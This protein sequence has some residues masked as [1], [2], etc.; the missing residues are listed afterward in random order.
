MATRLV[1]GAFREVWREIVPLDGGASQLVTTNIACDTSGLPKIDAR[2]VLDSVNGGPQLTATLG[3]ANKRLTI[4]IANTAPAGNLATWTLDVTLNH[5]A[6]Q[7]RGLGAAPTPAPV[8]VI[9]GGNAVTGTPLRAEVAQVA[10]S[11]AQYTSIAA[12]LA[13]VTP[14]ATALTPWVVQVAAGTYFEPPMTVPPYVTVE[15][16]GFVV[17]VPTSNGADLFTG[18]GSSFVNYLTILCP[19]GVGTAGFRVN[20]GGVGDALIANILFIG[21]GRYGLRVSAGGVQASNL[22]YGGGV[23]DK[24]VQVDGTGNCILTNTSYRTAVPA[25]TV[26]GFV[27]TGPAAVLRMSNC[28]FDAPGSIGTMVDDSGLLTLEG[29]QFIQGTIA[30]HVGNNGTPRMYARATSI[31]EDAT[32][33]FTTTIKVDTAAAVVHFQGSAPRN[34]FV[35]V[36]G[37]AL[38]ASFADVTPGDGGSTTIGDTYTARSANPNVAF[39]ESKYHLDTNWTGLRG[40]GDGGVTRA[41]GLKLDVAGDYGFINNNIDQFEIDWTT[42]QITLAPNTTEYVWIDQT[43]AIQH[44]P[45]QPNYANNIVL[46]QAVTD[47]ANVLLLTRD[48]IT[49]AHTLSRTQEFFEDVIGPI[50]LGGG[51]TTINGGDALKL[52]VDPGEF[53]VGLSERTIAGGAGVTFTYWY[54]T[55]GGWVGVPG[56]VHIDTTQYNDITSGLVAMTGTNW[57]KD[58]LYV[59]VNAGGTEYHVVYGQEQF[60][61]QVAAEQ[62]NYPAPPFI[63]SHYGMRSGGVVSQRN[64]VAITSTTDARPKIGG[65]ITTAG[66]SDH[67]ALTG[68][69]DDDHLQ[70]LTTGR[71]DTWHFSTPVAGE[72]HV[73][74]GNL[75]THSIAGDGGQV[76][77]TTLSNIGV[78]THVQID[79]H[80]ASTAN[81]HATTYTQVGAPPATR[82]LT[83]GAGLTGGGDLS[84]DRTFTVGANADG[85]I[86]VNA[87]DIQVGVLATDVQHG[88]R[89]GGA[90]HATVTADPGGVAGFMS[91]ADK[92]KLDGIPASA[93]PTTRTLTAGAGLTGGGDLSANR[94]FDVVANADGSIV[95]NADDIQV[96]VL[97]TDAQH[98]NRGGGGIHTLVVASGAAG[99]MSGADKTK[100]DGLPTSAVPTSRTINGFALTANIT[101]GA[102]DVSADVAGAAATVQGNLNTHAGL[103][104]TAHGGIVP[105][106]RTITAGNG[107]TGGGDLSANRALA[108][109]AANGSITVAA[110]GISVTFGTTATTACVGNDARLSDARL[111]LNYQQVN[112]PTRTTLTGAGSTSY[113]PAG[114]A[115]KLTMTTPA[116][117]AGTYKVSWSAVM[118][119]SSAARE[120][121]IRVQNTTDTVTLEE[122]L[123]RPTNAASP[124]VFTGYALVTFAGVAKTFAMQFHTANTGDTAGVQYAYLDIE[125]V[126]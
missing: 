46:A 74:N 123:F 107:L 41:G 126:L 95:V 10:K 83:A 68:L 57:K 103:T 59:I 102:A 72:A 39:P 26:H 96:G 61:T 58:L 70:Y 91:S 120:M 93:V 48:E 65:Y 87:N 113:P 20:G 108:V 97:A 14:L 73:K 52:D 43:G 89:G 9:L 28:L 51:A 25:S 122:V 11:G 60:A 4:T 64:A 71:A 69:G 42:T 105:S 45:A 31:Q 19:S 22:L 34:K 115:T 18:E 62:G 17:V 124:Q 29:V 49:I 75:H 6:Q 36:P 80:I 118:D 117:A 112:D 32:G 101:L 84:A 119:Y 66:V 121:S 63:L 109:L 40:D 3:I 27:C 24:Y 47:G 23:F 1:A 16:L 94:T 116:L 53:A 98:G 67:G 92:A 38:Q 77:H 90:L 44:G 13:V 88:N 111:P 125:R 76:D 21:S 54:E 7:N 99:F 106:A 35:L 56:Q 50:N 8:S 30:I 110:G 79:A 5:S 12:A 37:V 78:N 15:G 81:P 55:P 100:L 82:N 104:T 85:S 86:T 2:L 114:G 33:S